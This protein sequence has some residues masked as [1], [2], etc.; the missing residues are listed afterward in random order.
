MGFLW[1]ALMH[2]T[3]NPV[4]IFASRILQAYYWPLKYQCSHRKSHPW[5]SGFYQITEISIS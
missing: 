2:V 5:W 3:P 1:E 4:K